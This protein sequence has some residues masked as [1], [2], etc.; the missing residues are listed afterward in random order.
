MSVRVLSPGDPG[1]DL[2]PTRRSQDVDALANVL[3]VVVIGGGITGA[4][5]ALDAASRGL[6][7]ALL[8]ANDLA[9]GTSRWS[10]KL[11]HGGL[12]YLAT[13]DVLTAWESAVE[14]GHL[15]RTIAPFLIRPMAQVV[16]IMDDT[17]AA[18]ALL[19]RAG[20]AA[21]DALRLGART[22]RSTLPPARTLTAS[23]VRRLIPAVDG[24]RLRGGLLS[25]DGSLEDDA[26]LTIAVARTAAAYG[27]HIL[28]RFH[29]TEAHGDS[30]SAQCA[31]T[32]QTLTIRTRHVVNATGVWAE[33]F[34]AD[35]TITPSRGTHV[36]L[37]ADLLGNP[38]AAMTVPVADMRGRYCFLL[39]RPD[40][41]VI[42]GI[43]D[44]AEPGPIAAVPAVPADDVAWILRQ[45]SSALAVP[46]SPQDAVGAFTGLRPLV[47]RSTADAPTSDV[48]RQH[49]VAQGPNGVWTVTGGKLTTYRRM[50][51]DVVDHLT[52]R[53]CETTRIALIGAGG[54]TTAQDLPARLIRRYGAEAPRVAALADGDPQLLAPIAPGIPALGVEFAFGIRSEGARTPDDLIERRCRISLV[55]ADT[56]RARPIAA[57]FIERWLP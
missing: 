27:A 49:L 5:V 46:L 48:S 14:R 43:T 51:Q 57:E 15:M 24:T 13:G 35:I 29:V 34:D 11:V 4:G 42:A 52:A 50:A 6:T 55:D 54:L 36:V 20:F 40:G 47:H 41:L 25:W 53:P 16:P 39:P 18:S 32:G 37:R 22:L 45:V 44:V 9:F 12:R 7:V 31:D 19:T 1:A 17:S 33:A 21:G 30:V 26:R 10:S 28:T 8:E 38:R 2:S 56:Q 3:D 23:K